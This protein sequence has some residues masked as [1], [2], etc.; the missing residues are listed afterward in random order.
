MNSASACFFGTAFVLYF[1]SGVLYMGGLFI[2]APHWT[3]W[4][5]FFARFAFACHTLAMVSYGASVHHAPFSDAWESLSFF[6]WSLTL[7]FLALDWRV[8]LPS[9]GAFVIPLSFLAIFFASAQSRQSPPYVPAVQNNAL[10]IH[11][12]V[13]ILGYGSFALAFC[14][15]LVYLM[16]ERRLKRKRLDGIFQRLLPLEQADLIANRLVGIGFALLTLGLLMG[17]RFAAADWK[18]RWW[19]DPKVLSSLF[20]WAIY[21]LYLYTRSVAGWRGHRTML[22]LVAG[23]AAILI[24]YLGVNLSGAGR[25]AYPF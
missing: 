22:L 13:S 17:I 12:A 21:G 14:A 8:P 6:A 19:L 23:F 20:T 3:P 2:K 11:I 10:K 9:L 5:R 1:L 18:G 16:Q 4:A 7:L 15:A 24:G 25:H